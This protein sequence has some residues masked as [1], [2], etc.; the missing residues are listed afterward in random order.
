MKHNV[1]TLYERYHITILLLQVSTLSDPILHHKKSEKITKP[2][3]CIEYF[4]TVSLIVNWW[5]IC[6]LI[7]SEIYGVVL[8]V[9][10][11]NLSSKLK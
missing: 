8:G 7:H 5:L 9:N 4:L 10:E 3:K 2:L 11:V 1:N 6:Q